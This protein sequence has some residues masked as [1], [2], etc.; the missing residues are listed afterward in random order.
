MSAQSRQHTKRQQLLTER[1]KEMKFNPT[2]SER[3]LWEA[4]RGCRLG[5]AFRRQ[6]PIGGKYI[7]DFLAP[8]IRLVLEV[9]GG[10]HRQ[11]G[12]A[13]ERR[14]RNLRRLGY[15]VVRLNADDITRETERTLEG[16][17]AAIGAL[18]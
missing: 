10:V 3:V 14:D 9:D 4:L 15:T 16:I 1:A 6:V 2:W 11:R 17:R 12:V 13:D 5:V 7:A 18:L 8:A